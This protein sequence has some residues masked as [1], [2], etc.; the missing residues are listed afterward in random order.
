M[1][2][3]RIDLLGFGELPAETAAQRVVEQFR[4]QMSEAES[5]VAAAPVTL[6][7][8][9]SEPKTLGF[10]RILLLCGAQVEV[11][12]EQ[13]GQVDVYGV[14]EPEASEAEQPEQLEGKSILELIREEVTGEHPSVREEPHSGKKLLDLI[15]EEITGDAPVA[16]LEPASRVTVPPTPAAL[17]IPPPLESTVFD[18]DDD[19]AIPL[20][21]KPVVPEPARK[22]GKQLAA[23]LR[24]GGTRK[25]EEKKRKRP[26]F[27]KNKVVFWT[28]KKKLA[29]F[30]F[31]AFAIAAAAHLLTI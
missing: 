11:V 5:I 28:R 23:A 17:P 4:I 16:H 2:T 24:A 13:T 30:I 29:L 9:L 6:K 21:Q 1:N 12:H 15:R 22:R 14:E 7:A 20:P 3:F 27:G 19:L 26:K 25:K 8:G 10:V 18:D 31:V